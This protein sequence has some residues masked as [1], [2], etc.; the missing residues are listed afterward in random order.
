MENLTDSQLVQIKSAV[1]ALQGAFN[2]IAGSTS[3]PN[4]KSLRHLYVIVVRPRFSYAYAGWYTPSG[5]YAL[6][7]ANEKAIEALFAD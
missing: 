5:P 7:S 6:L 1:I 4:L 2:R 3:G